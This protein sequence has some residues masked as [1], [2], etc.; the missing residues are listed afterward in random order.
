[1]PGLSNAIHRE[2]LSASRDLEYHVHFSQF[3]IKNEH[4]IVKFWKPQLSQKVS[5][6]KA[7][8]SKSICEKFRSLISCHFWEIRWFIFNALMNWLF[9]RLDLRLN[10]VQ[11]QKER[12]SRIQ[13]TEY[14]L[15]RI[16]PEKS[17]T[18]GRTDT[19][20]FRISYKYNA[21]HNDG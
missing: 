6:S 5:H 9:I 7:L 4:A 17:E 14:F 10:V 2:F 16:V 19:L 13:K 8:A 15:L 18:L 21:C 1:M 11:F 3:F 12:Y 20:Y